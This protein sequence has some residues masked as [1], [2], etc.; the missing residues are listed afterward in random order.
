[1][2][3]GVVVANR[4]GDHSQ[5]PSLSDILDEPGAN[6]RSAASEIPHLNESA[7]DDAWVTR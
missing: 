1:V 4:S 2:V 3:L 6:I 7:W 5:R